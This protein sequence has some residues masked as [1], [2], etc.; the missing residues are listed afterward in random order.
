FLG[1]EHAMDFVV[2]HAR[3]VVALG[4]LVE[5]R[6]DVEQTAHGAPHFWSMIFSENR[7]PL[8]GIMLGTAMCWAGLRAMS[9][10]RSDTRELEDVFE[11]AEA[12]GRIVA[13]RESRLRDLIGA[14]RVVADEVEAFG[15]AVVVV[16]EQQRI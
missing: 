2:H 15:K 8:F 3:D 14:L 13:E 10:E 4:H 11:P 16:A 9:R 5:R 7:Y 12:H 6:D 1:L